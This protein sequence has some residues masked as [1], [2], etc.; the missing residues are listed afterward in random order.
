MKKRQNTSFSKEN[1][2]SSP[3]STNGSSSA[4]SSI[5]AISDSDAV[6]A[7]LDKMKLESMSVKV[8]GNLHPQSVLPDVG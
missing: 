1:L 7:Y 8:G 3:Y 6:V 5:P 4:T 2:E